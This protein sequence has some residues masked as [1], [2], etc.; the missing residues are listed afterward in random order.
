[1]RD[2]KTG[3]VVQQVPADGN[4]VPRRSTIAFFVV[5]ATWIGAVLAIPLA[6]FALFPLRKRGEQVGWTD[7]GPVEP[8]MNSNMPVARPVNIERK[9]GWQVTSGQQSVYVLAAKAGEKPRVVSAVCPH[10]GCTVQWS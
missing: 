10:L 5:A 6:R 8:F 2:D 4:A 1:M 9:D 3:A 7:L